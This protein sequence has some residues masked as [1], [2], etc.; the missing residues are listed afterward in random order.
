MGVL[1]FEISSDLREKL[2]QFRDGQWNWVAMKIVTDDVPVETIELVDHRRLADLRS[3]QQYVSKDEARFIVVKVPT[4]LTD[5]SSI[6]IFSCPE[7]VPIRMKMTMSSCKVST[8][9]LCNVESLICYIQASV[10]AAAQ[11][12][13][14]SFEK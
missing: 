9:F 10:I 2:V 13:G 7:S 3:L 12:L 4:M 11:S 14:L 8:E 6:F 5:I 1:P